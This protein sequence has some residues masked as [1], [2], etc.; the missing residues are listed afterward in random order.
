MHSSLGDY[1]VLQK[2]ETAVFSLL[3]QKTP[4]GKQQWSKFHFL[5]FLTVSENALKRNLAVYSYTNS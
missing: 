1:E 2:M 5:C 3:F 4:L